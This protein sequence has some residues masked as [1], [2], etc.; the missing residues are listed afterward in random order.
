[1]SIMEKARSLGEAILESTEYRELK[2][3]EEAMYNNEE[4]K[5]LLNELNAKQRQIQMAQANGKPIN[6][7]QQKEIQNI[8]ARMQTNDKVKDF[9]EAQKNFN[10]VMQTVN[11]TITSVL[12]E[13]NKDG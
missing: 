5:T 6:Q 7:K 10:Q 3:A 8:Q 1:M 11:Q 9:M 2:E 12:N 4:A 13:N